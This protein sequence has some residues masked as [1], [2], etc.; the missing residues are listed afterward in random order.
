MK[1]LV[2]LGVPISMGAIT[3]F[4]IIG[5]AAFRHFYPILAALIEP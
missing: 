4:V 5:Y 1:P 2:I 3:C